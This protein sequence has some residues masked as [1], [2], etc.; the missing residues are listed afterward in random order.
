MALADLTVKSVRAAVAE[1]DALGRE[2]FLRTHRFAEARTWFLEVDGKLY[3]VKPIVGVAHAYI[4]PGFGQL[5]SSYIRGDESAVKQTLENMGFKVV[6]IGGADAS[7]V[8]AQ[9]DWTRD[10]LILALD[11]YL[12][13]GAPT[14][15]DDAV[16]VELTEI[17]ARL[18]Q[19]LGRTG[20][21]AVR[22]ASAVHRTMDA[23]VYLDPTTTRR[24]SAREGATQRAVWADFHADRAALHK[25][26][27][28]IRGVI[29]LPMGEAPPDYDPDEITE[30]PEGRVFTR[31]HRYRERNRALV[32]QRKQTARRA[33]G[34][35]ACEA[36]GF[37]FAA[38]YGVRGDGYIE[39]HHTRPVSTLGEDARTRLD[40]LALVCANC[41]RMIHAR[42]PW[43]SLSDLKALIGK[44]D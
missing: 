28:T 16:V 22:S 19:T 17:L 36:C 20:P 32:E 39:A 8:G 27:A 34:K 33:S 26:A 11:V 38:A 9:L 7:P 31:L 2:A 10:E 1:F 42:Q 13:R 35:L 23:F 44:N 24:G 25:I 4:G 3:D 6:K 12:R 29:E 41:H 18:N 37:D 15:P 40:D 30:A 21:M 43:L 5:R 14:G